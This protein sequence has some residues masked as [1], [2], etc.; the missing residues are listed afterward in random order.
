MSLHGDT[1]Q[2]YATYRRLV[3][4]NRIVSVLRIGVPALGVV[5]LVGLIGQI[6][7]SSLGSRFDV[8]RLT[9][10]PESVIVEAPEYTGTLDDGTTYHISATQAQAATAAVDQVGLRDADLEMTRPDG[11]E[12]TV[13]AAAATLDT[14]RELVLIPGDAWIGN[15][16]GTRGVVTDSIFNYQTQT[17]TG[18]GP[19]TIDYADGTHL[20][21]EGMTYDALTLVWTF[22]RATVTLPDTP[23]ADRARTKATETETP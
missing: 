9:V 17:L 13:Q 14:T 6:Y 8:G 7:L 15:S 21:A 3:A 11:V 23:G 4:R 20:L 1:A 12:M 19:V 18:E 16:L 2:R 10:T 22:T 5:V